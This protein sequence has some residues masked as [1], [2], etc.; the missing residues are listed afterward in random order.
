MNI[1]TLPKDALFLLALE[2]DVPDLLNLCSSISK[3]DELICQKKDI[4]LR[5][6]QPFYS[7]TREILADF[8]SLSGTHKLS[9]PNSTNKDILRDTKGI[10]SLL[11][12]LNVVKQFYLKIN[13]VDKDR[14]LI[15]I[16]NFEGLNLADYKI[17]VIPK[18]LGDL[19]NL[20]YLYLNS[21]KIKEL[22]SSFSN[23][24]NLKQLYLYKN[25]ITEIPKEIFNIANLQ[26]LS[27]SDNQI[28]EIP[29]ELGDL[30]NLQV[31]FLRSNQI[32]ELP[33]ELGALKDLRE[34]YLDNNQI[35]TIPKGL[36]KLNK[37]H[38]I[39]LAKN[40]IDIN[41]LPEEIKNKLV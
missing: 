28:K 22:P 4:W 31:L 41:N 10:Y 7:S 37:L 13:H 1:S 11:Y 18:E 5:K 12:S 9:L 27:L 8:D 17:E 24:I 20:R 2:L 3:I 39:S 32:K 40:P 25:Q 14:S 30:I 15:E 35:T 33:E 38:S 16:Y 23:L 36:I 29:K 34:L 21:N 6:L 19:I 26:V